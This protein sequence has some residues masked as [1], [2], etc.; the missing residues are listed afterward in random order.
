MIS[1]KEVFMHVRLLSAGIRVGMLLTLLVLACGIRPDTAAAV[2][3][4]RFLIE[5]R[6]EKLN[7]SSPDTAA[8]VSPA[9]FIE[10]HAVGSSAAPATTPT[11]PAS[12]S[13][14]IVIQCA[15]SAIGETDTYTFTATHDDKVVVR[16]AMTSGDLDPA[17]HILDP[18][19]T[20]ICMAF[21]S[22]RV[23][24]ISNC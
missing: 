1:N 7:N 13:F 24:E 15:I 11:C 10:M 8:A 16:I 2:S 5:E 14:G 22:E 20:Q 12:L 18:A 17:I 23:A 21:T 9:R 6:N 4:T 3:P 19:R